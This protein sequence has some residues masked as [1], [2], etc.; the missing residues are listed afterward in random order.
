METAITTLSSLSYEALDYEDRE[1]L[2]KK[3]TWHRYVVEAGTSKNKEKSL[4]LRASTS[5][6]TVTDISSESSFEERKLVASAK[7][8]KRL[9]E[10]L[11]ILEEEDEMLKKALMESLEE[12]TR[13]KTEVYQYIETLQ[14]CHVKGAQEMGE[15][16]MDGINII[17]PLKD[18]REGLLQVLIQESNPSLVTRDLRPR[19]VGLGIQK[20][21]LT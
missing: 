16:S 9:D 11:R 3:R 17:K 10:R 5:N 8:I 15:V 6:H 12:R 14:L 18:R 20:V 1:F 19:A 4:D 13:L 2:G 21:Q 7:E